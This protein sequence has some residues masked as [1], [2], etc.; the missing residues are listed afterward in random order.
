MRRTRRR[1]RAEGGGRGGD[2]ATARDA[3]AGWEVATEAALARLAATAIAVQCWQGDDVG[4]FERRG[5]ASRGAIQAAGNHPGRARTPD[6]LRAELDFACRMIPG[7][8]RLNLHAM[9][10]DTDTVPDRDA[11]EYRQFVP[12]VGRGRA[13]G[14][15]GSTSTRP[16]SA[17]RKPQTT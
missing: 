1:S 3:F 12:C 17:T 15:S 10:P 11:I 5:R 13:T 7:R 9:Y 4:G 6:E 2:Y 16:S 14:A 8:D